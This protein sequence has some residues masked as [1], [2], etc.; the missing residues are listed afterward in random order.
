MLSVDYKLFKSIDCDD[1]PDSFTS[2]GKYYY[3]VDTG[4]VYIGYTSNGTRLFVK[5]E[6]ADY[7]KYVYD[8]EGK[9]FIGVKGD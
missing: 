2:S 1:I 3:Q 5:L 4:V 7:D 6:S 8:V 9:E